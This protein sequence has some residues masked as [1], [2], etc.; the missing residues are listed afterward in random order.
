MAN[1]EINNKPTVLRKI[2]IAKIIADCRILADKIVREWKPIDPTWKTVK[3]CA[4]L[5]L[6]TDNQVDVE[7]GSLE[8]QINIAV[9][10]TIIRSNSS[11]IN[12][13]IT[14]FFIEPGVTGRDDNRPEFQAMKRNIKRGFFC[15]VVFKEIARISRNAVQWKE[16][17]RLCIEKEC[18]V[19]IRGLPFNPNDPTQLLQLDILAAF[20]EYESNINSKRLKESNFSAML[21]SGKFNSTQP[22]LG[23]DPQMVN[24]KACPGFYTPNSDDLK[25]VE[26]IMQTFIKYGSY[27]QTID[28]CEKHGIVNRNGQ[29]FLKNSLHTLL[30]NKRYIGQWEVNKESKDKIQEKLMPYDRY[31][32]V[33]LPHGCVID[34]TLWDKVQKTVTRISNIRQRENGVDRIYL[35]SGILQHPDGSPFHGRSGKGRNGY[36]SLYYTNPKNNISINAVPVEEEAKKMVSEIIQKTPTLKSALLRR[37]EEC[38]RITQLLDHNVTTVVSRIAELEKEKATVDRRLDFLL[39]NNDIKA[40]NEFME[41]YVV[42]AKSLITE[43]TKHQAQLENLRK[44]RKDLEESSFNWREVGSQ[45][46]KIQKVIQENDPAALKATYR[47][48]F[49]KIIICDTDNEGVR[50]IHFVLRNEESMGVTFEEKGSVT[51]KRAGWTGLEPAASG[52]TGRRY[53]QLNYHPASSSV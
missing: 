33:D 29:S 2:R 3:G 22:I 53:N 21:T 4:Y 28:V 16:F 15:F 8:Q 9:S 27:K 6:S 40:A 26:W 11:K 18:D 5:R 35:L 12:Y 30:T 45:A 49:E 13:Q 7:K 52:V 37:A 31:A 14:H 50:Q 23:L 51:E 1:C 19:F 48:L 10:E 38:S 41:E 32:I 46:I 36:V 39:S 42:S 47:E 25:K 17:F 20:A 24:G 43:I 44:K 34:K